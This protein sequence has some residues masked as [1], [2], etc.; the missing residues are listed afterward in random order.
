MPVISQ[1]QLL[2]KHVVC[3]R[4]IMNENGFLFDLSAQ[5][6][7]HLSPAWMSFVSK[8]GMSIACSLCVKGNFKMEILH[9]FACICDIGIRPGA[10][11]GKLHLVDKNRPSQN[12]V[13]LPI[14]SNYSGICRPST[15]PS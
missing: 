15:V 14:P 6:F 4:A 3:R 11:R 9:E 1:R 8:I 2:D 5:A 10:H 7:K 12:V 13:F